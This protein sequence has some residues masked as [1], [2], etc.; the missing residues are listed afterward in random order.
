MHW[1]SLEAASHGVMTPKRLTESLLALLILVAF[2]PFL[3]ILPILIRLTS[4]GP[5]F[6]RAK[7]LGMDGQAFT[8]LKFRSMKVD[9]PRITTGENVT[10]IHKDDDRLTPIG[11]FLRMGF[12]ELP[13]LFSVLT[14]R[15]ALIGPRPDEPEDLPH[16]DHI[17]RR[18]LALR[19]GISG[20]A[21]I[22]GSRELPA[23]ER[24]LL[25][26]W[27]VDHISLRLDLWVFGATLL[28]IAGIRSPGA[29]RLQRILEEAR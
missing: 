13:Q 14:G 5:V 12:D 1:Q 15:M 7:R 10:V 3:L 2:S 20:L 17:A 6:Y 18:R 26:A 28:Y 16:Y 9:A 21:A 29:R 4:S 11:R 25:D 8:L 23:K 19:P 24:Y 22:C 27:Y